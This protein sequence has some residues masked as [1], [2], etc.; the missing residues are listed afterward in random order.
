MKKRCRAAIIVF[1]LF[2]FGS[3][4]AECGLTTQYLNSLLQG[5]L[6]KCYSGLTSNTECLSQA[7]LKFLQGMQQLDAN[8]TDQAIF[9]FEEAVKQDPCHFLALYNLGRAYFR[10]GAYTK[11]KIQFLKLLTYDPPKCFVCPSEKYLAYIEVCE[12]KQCVNPWRLQID[13][14]I[15]PGYN[16]N[17]NA[18]PVDPFVEVP[19]IGFFLLPG[20]ALG[21]PDEF[22]NGNVTVQVSHDFGRDSY[23]YGMFST[24]R[25]QTISLNDF[26]YTIYSGELGIYHHI[27]RFLYRVPV[28]Y[29]VYNSGS[30]DT[31]FRQFTAVGFELLYQLNV[32]NYV[33]FNIDYQYFTYPGNEQQNV[34]NA[35]F[36][37]R[38]VIRSDS[39]HLVFDNRIYYGEQHPRVDEGAFLTQNSF[40]AQIYGTYTGI[41]CHAPY[42]IVNAQHSDYRGINPVFDRWREDRFYNIAVGW[43]WQFAKGWSLQPDYIASWNFSNFF[44]SRF[45]QNIVQVELKYS[46]DSRGT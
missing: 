1:C 15:K 42:F 19:I 8:Q 35:L 40:G 41:R 9:S 39:K 7:D 26:N 33:G 46:F 36:T 25:Q 17:I 2:V 5:D 37:G 32:K 22:A 14:S 34:V 31:T 20:E 38:W 13:I 28:K 30:D 18:A 21:Q 16:D 12:R 44:S 11:A 24:R 23:F 4:S 10:T 3:A 27:G 29:E 43:N 45:S 6:T